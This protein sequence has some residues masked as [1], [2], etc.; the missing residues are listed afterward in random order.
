MARLPRKERL[1]RIVAG[2]LIVVAQLELW[3]GHS[4]TGV[5]RAWA[6]LV[7]VIVPATVA[8]RRRWPLAMGIVAI[9]ATASIFATGGKNYN[10]AIGIAWMCALYAIAVWT[11]LTGFLLGFV[12]LTVTNIATLAGPHTSVTNTFQFT[13]IPGVAM[14]IARRAVRDRELEARTHAAR[15]ELAEREH[16]LR[17]NQAI[18]EERARIARELH[19]LVAHN[20]S[21]MVIQAGAE[22][23]ALGD[24]E[25]STRETLGSIEE[26]GRQALS[27]ARRLLGVLRRGDEREELSP[28]P[29]LAQIG[30]L[31]E[32]VRRAGLPV[33]MT[34]EGD[35]VALPAGVDLCAYRV[36]QEGLTNALKHAGPAHARVRVRYDPHTLEIDV[37]DDGRGDQAGHRNGDGHDLGCGHGLI[38][39]RER[40]ALYGGELTS[41]PRDD[42]GFALHARLPLA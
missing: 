13:V 25:A 26:A 2:I 12:T 35:A 32:Q 28:Q 23:H 9:V 31:V 4:V 40:V 29:S 21:V 8:F 27:E 24:R 36:V 1:D 17:A 14:L 6:A 20:V 42:G 16:E 19:D 38:G 37:S 10:V 7:A 39:M 15:A 22:R 34:V 5:P 11:D 3:V 18:A 30:S 41:G 33:E